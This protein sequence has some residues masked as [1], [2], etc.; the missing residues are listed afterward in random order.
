M[1]VCIKCILEKDL[2]MFPKKGN[3]CKSCKSIYNNNYSKK[4]R[5][6][7]KEILSEYKK[8]YYE[9]NK[10]EISIKSREHREENKD[11]IKLMKKRYYEENKEE[12]SI[13]SKEYYE[14]NREQLSEYYKKYREENKIK[15]KEYREKNK[16]KLYENF[17][18][19][20]KS[21]IIFKISFISRNMIGRSFRRAGY[22]KKSKTQDIIGCSFEEFKL[23]L[24]SKFEDWMNWEN[25]GLYNGE[26]NYGWDVDHIIPLSSAKTEEDLIKLNHYTNLQPLCSKINRDIKRDSI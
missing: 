8:R 10:E 6:E 11:A 17:K 2:Y 21:D 20:L 15:S 12:I 18:N 14:E 4:Y 25:R 9:E 23:H 5:E 3:I 13:K 24:E 26:L 1:K 7:N 16:E 22:S 19:R